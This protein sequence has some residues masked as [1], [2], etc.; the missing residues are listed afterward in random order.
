M[1]VDELIAELEEYRGTGAIVYTYADYGQ[2]PER[3][4][5][6]GETRFKGE[7]PHFGEG[8]FEYSED[9]AEMKEGDPNWFDEMYGKE[10]TAI[11]IG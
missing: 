2:T 10:V 4:C 1:T 9:L 5:C 6:V 7:L 3:A 8:L 11:M